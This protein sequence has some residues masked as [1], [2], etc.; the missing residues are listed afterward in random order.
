M[1]ASLSSTK[2]ELAAIATTRFSIGAR[3]GEIAEATADP[4]GW[5]KSQIGKDKA[6]ITDSSL[7][8]TK[9]AAQTSMAYFQ[10]RR[11]MR[12]ARK[13]DEA[14]QAEIRKNARAFRQNFF[15][16]VTARTSHALETSN[17]FAERWARFWSNHFTVSGRKNEIIALIGPYERDVIRQYCFTD[18]ATLLEKATLHPAMLVYLDNHR[19]VGP[20]TKP[21]TRRNLGL[22]ENLARELLELHTLSVKAGYTQKD[23]EEMARALTG[24]TL[25]TRPFKRD[26]DGSTIFVSRIHEPGSRTIL[27]KKF[28]EDGKSQVKAI[29]KWLATHPATAEHIA[30]KLAIHFVSDIPPQSAIDTLRD[31]FL[32]TEGDLRALAHAIIDLEEAWQPAPQKFKSPE[33][34]LISTGRLLGGRPVYGSGGARKIFQSLGQ[35]PLMAPSP[36]GWS[37]TADSWAGPDAIKKR[38][39]WANRTARRTRDV[40]P[41]EFLNEALGPLA[42]ARTATAIARA[43]SQ[44]QGLTLAIMSPEFQRR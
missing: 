2:A 41:A 21:A 32:E 12:N 42:S 28:S 9:E 31:T 44:L 37:D 10:E 18:F 5:L 16:E 6:R 13:E 23:V 43:E 40:A 30:R 14:L 36:Q 17:G 20:S 22:N 33:E 15:R 25:A 38:L 26:G 3:E 11:Q 39:E 29:L 4:R 27:G 34:L 7:P 19:S 1:M 24:W 35:T 8:S